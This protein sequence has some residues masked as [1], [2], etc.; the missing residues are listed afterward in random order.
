MLLKYE[1]GLKQCGTD[2]YQLLELEKTY[3][4][5]KKDAQSTESKL[6][7]CYQNLNKAN[8]DKTYFETLFDLVKGNIEEFICKSN[9]INKTS[10]DT[11]TEKLTSC[12]PGWRCKSFG[13][14][15]SDCVKEIYNILASIKTN[16][17][18]KTN[19]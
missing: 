9:G 7:K 15:C 12:K 10:C 18:D 14:S 17:S 16:S 5:L 13:W 1:N 2:L 19:A 11:L 6:N 8:N 4:N 3:E